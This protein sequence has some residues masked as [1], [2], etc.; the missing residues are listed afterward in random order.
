MTPPDLA[1]TPATRLAELLRDG[2]ITARELT[3]TY[4]DR[5]ERLNPTLNAYRA[6]NRSA[7]DEADHADARRRA[8]D[9]A[10]LLGLPIAVKDNLAIAGEITT[11]G[12][13][14]G[15]TAAED[16]AAVKR[17]REQGAV[18]LGMTNL[19]E[20]ALW[21]HSTESPAFGQTRNPYDTTRSPGGSSGGSAVAVAA[22]LAAAAIGTDGGGSIRVPAAFTGLVGLKPQ[23]D[24]LS[25]APDEGHWLGL[26]HLGTL[27]RTV[28]D[29]ALLAGLDVAP[30]R[31]LRIAVST[32]TVLPAKPHADVLASLERVVA[33]AQELG[34]QTFARDPDYGDLRPLFVPRY[35]RGAY[36]DAQRIG[37]DLEPRARSI[38]RLGRRM[39]RLA[40]R[41]RAGEAA[42]AQRINRIFDDADVV[43]TPATAAPAPKLGHAYHRSGVRTILAISA[44]SAYT[45]PWNVTGQPAL[46]IPA[47]TD[48][49]GVPLGVQLVGR[50]GDEATILGLAAQLEDRKFSAPPALAR[51]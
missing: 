5:I 43:L 41:A 13:K 15:V 34:H 45:I 19:P 16:C 40:R 48:A 7:L 3:Q 4:L 27:T 11:H 37:R 21:P 6:T 1:F 32:K 30:A 35:L 29:A 33:L 9:T 14:L 44:Y 38:V 22:G 2:T 42:R 50:P 49:T 25:L 31:P 20:L 47:G 26:T 18:I 24:R 8:G 46:A 51:V 28:E 23:R 12:T 10:H 17:L 36:E 39:D